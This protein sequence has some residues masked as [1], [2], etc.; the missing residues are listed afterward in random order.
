MMSHPGRHG[1]GGKRFFGILCAVAV[2]AGAAFAAPAGGGVAIIDLDRVATAL[3]WIEDLSKN[4]QAT[5]A[6]LRAQIDQALR[7]SVKAIED[8]K[9]EV[10]AEAKLT[11][12]QIKTLNA[13]Q[14]IRDLGQLPLTNLQR[15]KLVNA[16]QQANTVLQNSQNT[17]QQQIQQRRAALIRGYRDKIR[18][19]ARRVAQAHG[20]SVV[21]VTGDNVLLVEPPADITNE[22][23]DELQKSN[24]GKGSAP[25][26][27]ESPAA[28]KSTR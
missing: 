21:L 15:E 9:A 11:M 10:A 3:G 18:P 7:A 17:Y 19:F 5:D 16:V 1:V 24:I 13:I 6:E 12:D 25:A 4:L 20:F 23:I 2:F 14:D 8:A 27:T 22:V 26:A 28:P